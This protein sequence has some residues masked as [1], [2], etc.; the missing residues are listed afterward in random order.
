MFNYSVE[1]INKM[2]KYVINSLVS[3]YRYE[4]RDAIKIVNDSVFNQLILEDTEYV[5]HY[6]VNYWAKE[7]L[8]GENLYKLEY[9]S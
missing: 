7:V 9:S 3:N 1:E 6:S 5:F 4:N 8:K 2:K